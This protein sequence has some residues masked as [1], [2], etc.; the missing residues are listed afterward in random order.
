MQIKGDHRRAVVARAIA[1]E[2]PD[3][4]PSVWLEH[5]LP[6]DMKAALGARNPGFR[7]GEDLPDFEGGEVE[8]ARI[9]LDTVHREVT[10]LRARIHEDDTRALRLVEADDG[11]GF[12][13]SDRYALRLVQEDDGSGVID[14][15]LDQAVIDHAPTGEEV[16]RQFFEPDTCPFD[17][18][19]DFQISS[20]L[21]PDIELITH[22]LERFGS[23]ERPDEG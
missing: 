18:Q 3:A 11:C 6:E 14:L 12:I 20:L 9:T 15:P 22:E 8:L 4:V 1:E 21:Y 13:E 16:V 2:G 7:G 19:T 17:T 5:E 23:V 10:S